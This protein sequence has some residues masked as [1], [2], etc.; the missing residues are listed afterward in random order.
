MRAA[1]HNIVYY[2]GMLFIVLALIGGAQ[3]CS[4]TF[5]TG[6]S[7]GDAAVSQKSTEKAS[8]KKSVKKK[9]GCGIDVLSVEVETSY[10]G[11]PYL[12]VTLSWKNRSGETAAFA[13]EIETEATQGSVVIGD[14]AADL[15]V[16]KIYGV[17]SAER[18]EKMLEN[19]SKK[20]VDGASIQTELV[21]ELEDSSSPVAVTLTDFCTGRKVLKKTFS[22]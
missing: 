12:V 1:I 11:N 4:N 3:S 6:S 15:I 14:H 7:D 2:A 21:L 10:G 16:D 18:H 9:S 19:K 17:P 20:V 8:E 13:S 5:D 22:L